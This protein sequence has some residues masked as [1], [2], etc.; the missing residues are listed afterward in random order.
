MIKAK[1]SLQGIDRLKPTDLSKRVRDMWIDL[2]GKGKKRVRQEIARL[3]DR[4]ASHTDATRARDPRTMALVEDAKIDKTRQ[5][6]AKD[7]FSLDME[8]SSGQRVQCQVEAILRD[9]PSD[10]NDEG[11]LLV[12]AVEP[13]GRRWLLFSPIIK[14]QVSARIGNTGNR[15]ILLIRGATNE[16]NWEECVAL[17]AED[18]VA[19]NEWVEMLGSNPMPP[20][21]VSRPDDLESIV[22]TAVGDS[23]DV[24]IPIGERRRLE[25]EDVSD[26]L[27]NSPHASKHDFVF[28]KPVAR[29]ARENEAAKPIRHARA[30][31]HSQTKSLPASDTLMSGAL[32]TPE[33]ETQYVK[34]S[35][36]PKS[37][38][39]LNESMR[40]IDLLKKQPPATPA[41]EDTPPPPPAH[42]VLTT[43]NTLKKLA[44]ILETPTSK[45][46]NKRTSS[47]LKHEYQP[48]NASESSPEDEDSEED[49]TFSESSDEEELA[50]AELAEPTYPYSKRISPSASIYS[51]PNTTLAPSNSASQAPYRGVPVQRSAPNAVKLTAAIS[52]WTGMRWDD[53][54]PG[55]CSI[56]VSPGLIEAFELTAAHAQS[57]PG[58]VPGEPDDFGRVNPLVGLPLTPVVL[59]RKSTAVDIEVNSPPIPES[60]LRC[61]GRVRFRALTAP[62]CS[63][64]YNAINIARTENPVYKKLEEEARINSFGTNAYEKAVASSRRR[65]SFGFLGRKKSYRASSEMRAVEVEPSEQASQSSSTFSRL[66]RL[67]GSGMFNLKKS[68]IEKGPGGNISSVPSSSYGSRYSGTSDPTPPMSPSL[69]S[70]SSPGAGANMTKYGNENLKIRLYKV[71]SISSWEDRGDARLSITAPPPGMR[72]ASSLYNGVEK[73]IIVKIKA[74]KG[75]SIF[76]S[77]TKEEEEENSFNVTVL[78]VVLGSGNFGRMGRTGVVCD[79]WEDVRGDDGRVGVV[80]RFGPSGGV[81]RKWLFQCKGLADAGWVFGLTQRGF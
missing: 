41:E 53:M 30:R 61:T 5:V 21:E 27:K 2:E 67:S 50:A 59:L 36:T 43:P 75:I 22:S 11:D 79:I 26:G 60:R 19:A 31:Y 55:Q 54:H 28:D 14:K 71:A 48:S 52:Q 77:G 56:V 63:Q 51:L 68:S 35:E 38:S 10:A 62:A 15:V 73:R 37:S 16:Q 80:G 33:P 39:P 3:V 23:K 81:K 44:P 13:S 7:D 47:P 12:R 34:T 42:K 1:V 6:C 24:E 64:L 32:P 65:S 49:D 58:A 17:N 8:H 9:K 66:R 78:D 76:S 45:N 20:P 46:K 74:P 18:P 70:A 25:T 40:P 4:D 72:P 29:H 57:D 69:A